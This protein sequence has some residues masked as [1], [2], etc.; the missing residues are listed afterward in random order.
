MLLLTHTSKTCEHKLYNPP[1]IENQQYLLCQDA[2]IQCYQKMKIACW[3]RIN[4]ILSVRLNIHVHVDLY[5]FTMY[6]WNLP[7]KNRDANG[8]IYESFTSVLLKQVLTR[9]EANTLKSNAYVKKVENIFLFCNY[10]HTHV[11]TI[12]MFT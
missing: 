6:T 3:I 12:F 1:R 2:V 7:E 10:F 11:D 5:Q 9:Q 4:I 8:W